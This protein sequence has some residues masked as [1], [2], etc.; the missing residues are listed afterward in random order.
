MFTL[1]TILY[2]HKTKLMRY[3]NIVCDVAVAL[4]PLYVHA[5]LDGEQRQRFIIEVSL[6]ELHK[7]LVILNSEINTLLV[8]TR[9][10]NPAAIFA[11][12]A[13]A[14]QS[15][16]KLRQKD[17]DASPLRDENVDPSTS[18]TTASRIMDTGVLLIE[19]AAA[20]DSP[21]VTAEHL[22]ASVAK[23]KHFIASVDHLL[24]AEYRRALRIV[25]ATPTSLL[26]LSD[27]SVVGRSAAPKNRN[28]SD[29][30]LLELGLDVVRTLCPQHGLVGRSVVDSGPLV[31]VLL[32][33][34]SIS[35]E[36]TGPVVERVRAL[37]H[38]APWGAC[39]VTRRLLRYCGVDSDSTI[40]VT[41]SSGLTGR[42]SGSWEPWRV[43][44]LPKVS[45]A[46]VV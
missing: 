11:G 34:S 10:N 20:V 38:V 17:D 31:G 7:N 39:F 19:F 25:K 46:T 37:L 29:L 12:R 8:T 26:I 18:T 24:E 33:S 35:F 45:V 2:P 44:G 28:A 22:K 16:R 36:F 40:C 43:K 13:Q 15:N 32:G 3:I 41:T 42:T 6:E 30:P 9:V 23:A 27:V 14:R 4:G 5:L 21:L 1:Q